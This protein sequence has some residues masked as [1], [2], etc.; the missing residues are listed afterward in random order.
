VERSTGPS[1]Q[2]GRWTESKY[3]MKHLS[4]PNDDSF[5]LLKHYNFLAN[6]FVNFILLG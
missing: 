6:I 3:S 2:N 5:I 4:V 1:Q